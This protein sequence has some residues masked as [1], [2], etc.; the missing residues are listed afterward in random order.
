MSTPKPAAAGISCVAI[1]GRT[2]EASEAARGFVE[3]LGLQAVPVE[4]SGSGSVVAQLD[5]LRE[6]DFAIVMLSAADLGEGSRSAFLSIGFLL[7][8]L[9]KGR[10]CCLLA[11]PS[12]PVPELE[13]MPRH[14]IDA[15]GL[16]RLL[17]AREMRQAGLDVD[18]N[19]AL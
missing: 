17:L 8:V 11:D 15:G 14:A 12:A 6:L 16:W 7:G 5:G 18:M 9:P 4:T 2:D 19:K 10:L 13:G 3:Q 1:V